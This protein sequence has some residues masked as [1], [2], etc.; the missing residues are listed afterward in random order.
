MAAAALLQQ[1]PLRCHHRHHHR[2]ATKLP[3]PPPSSLFSFVVIAVIVAISVTIATANFSLLL[4]DV[5]APAIVVT[6]GVFVATAGACGGSLA[7]AAA[8]AATAAMLPPGA[9]RMSGQRWEHCLVFGWL[10]CCEPPPFSC[11]QKSSHKLIRCLHFTNTKLVLGLEICASQ[12]HITYM[13][14]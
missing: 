8:A 12:T 4:I 1:P 11:H 14:L 7:V 3:P 9:Q 10:V 6:A 5:C 13:C 2:A